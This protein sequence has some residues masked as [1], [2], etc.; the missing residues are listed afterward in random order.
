M[1]LERVIAPSRPCRC[2]VSQPIGVAA[3][4]LLGAVELGELSVE[5]AD[6]QMTCLP[7]HLEDQAVGEAPAWTSTVLLESGA[8]DV[9]VRDRQ[10]L[11][12]EEHLDGRGNRRRTEVVD[13]VQYPG[14]LGKNHVADPRPGGHERLR[15]RDLPDVVAR[16]QADEDI[17]VNGA[18]R[19][20]VYRRMPSLS[21][22]SVF[23]FGARRG[24]SARCTSSEEKRP[25]RRTTMAPPRSP[26]S[27]IAPGPT[28]KRRRTSAGTDTWPCAVSFE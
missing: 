9:G 17:R 26:H 8:D 21:C 13:G 14:R 2:S 5:G 15:G 24:K 25:A 23:G 7:G 28:P 6:R 16:D 3:L 20:R 27:R 4:Q 12:V 1:I 11:V 19:F 10:V 22:P 18:C